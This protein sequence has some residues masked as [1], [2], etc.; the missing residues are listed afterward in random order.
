MAVAAAARDGLLDA[1]DDRRDV[2]LLLGGAMQAAVATVAAGPTVDPAA[3]V[4][5]DAALERF[6]QARQARGEALLASYDQTAVAAMLGADAPGQASSM[7]QLV[8]SAWRTP[9]QAAGGRLGQVAALELGAQADEL[10]AMALALVD[11]WRI[12]TGDD[13]GLG[14]RVATP[15][16]AGAIAERLTWLEVWTHADARVGDVGEM[17]FACGLALLDVVDELAGGRAV[18]YLGL[19]SEATA[20]ALITLGVLSAV[21]QTQAA[22]GP[23]GP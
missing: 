15:E 5:A 22:A 1:G 6:A 21:C 16:L 12:E 11:L 4:R 9:G 18:A 13:G 8:L 19:P 23:L 3:R 2:R 14:E 20:A 17:W 7:L 10:G